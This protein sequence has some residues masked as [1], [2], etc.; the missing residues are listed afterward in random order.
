M[1]LKV[2]PTKIAAI[3][4]NGKKTCA[5]VRKETGCDICF[6]GTLYNMKNYHPNC[7]VKINGTVL[8]KDECIYQGYGWNDGDARGTPALSSSMSSWYNFISCDMMINNGE[9]QTMYYSESRGGVRKGRTAFGYDK[10][11]NMIIFVSKNGT[12]DASTIKQVQQKM[13]DQGCINAICLDGGG[14]SQIDSDIAK[15]TSSRK[16]ANWICVWIDGCPFAEPAGNVKRGS[17]GTAAKWVQWHLNKLMGADL[18]VDGAFGPLSVKA[19]IAFQSK[20]GLV[21]DGICG[22]LTRAKMKELIK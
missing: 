5:Q 22:K 18:Q 4:T 9:L 16:V 17:S 14:S 8:N 21:A 11:G 15:I 2:K 3:T 19:L 1:I 10:N 12:A 13:F 20:Y 7:D 6:N